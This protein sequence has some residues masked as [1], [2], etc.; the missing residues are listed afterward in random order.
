MELDARIS[1][2]GG[3]TG[4]IRF[5]SKLHSTSGIIHFANQISA[6]PF[7]KVGCG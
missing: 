2:K 1:V 6:L 5:N 3:N 4:R 7:I